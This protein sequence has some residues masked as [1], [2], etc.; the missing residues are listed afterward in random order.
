M[1]LDIDIVAAG[2][3]DGRRAA[4]RKKIIAGVAEP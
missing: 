2:D 1:S 3:P 4:D